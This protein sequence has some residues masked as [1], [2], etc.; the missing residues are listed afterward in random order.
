MSDDRANVLA[1][2]SPE[3]Q[4]LRGAALAKRLF[5]I[6]GEASGDAHGGKLASALL[7]RNP[8]LSLEGVGGAAMEKAGVRLRHDIRHLGVV[9]LVEV[10]SQWRSIWRTY[11]DVRARLREAPPD[12]LVL[13]DY[14]EFNLRIARLAKALGIPVI[15][16]VSPQIWAWRPGRIAAIKSVVDLMLVLFEFEAEVYRTA[17]VPCRLVGHPLLDDAA[18]DADQ[19]TFARRYRLATGE[20]ALGLLPG[21]RALEVSRLLPA[22]LDAAE[23]LHAAGTIDRVLVAVAPSIDAGLVQSLVD[24]TGAFRARVTVAIGEA[25]AVLRAS[26]AAVVA[27]GTATLQ[28]A[29]IGTPLVMV[30]RVAPLTAWI[31]RLLIT[32]PHVALVNVVAGRRVVPELVQEQMTA[33]RIAAE[34]GRILTDE[35]TASAMRADLARVRSAL[36]EP[37]ASARA[38][39]ATLEWLAQGARHG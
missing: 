8:A 16:Y 29:V 24:R 31:A 36:G 4:G 23:R 18:P 37:G 34:V 11:R 1:P 7:A 13:I 10:L 39:E 17:G 6:A 14:P 26:R 25:A 35:R 20:R 2:P 32:I 38:A 30:Y 28:A 5:L 22:M 21:S 3:T 27:S 15:Y 12:A 19:E 33:E 9:G